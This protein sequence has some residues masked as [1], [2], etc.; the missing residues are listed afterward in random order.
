MSDFYQAVVESIDAEGGFSNNP[1]D[2][3]NWTSGIVGKGELKGTKY[4]ISAAS[5]PD[6]DIENL[7]VDDAK[8]IYKR[9]WWDKYHYGAIESQELANKVFDVSINMGATQAH[10]LLQRATW[11]CNGYLSIK[12]DG[13]IGPATLSAL[14]SELHSIALLC[15]FKSEIAGFYRL[16]AKI[17]TNDKEN[18]SGWLKNRAYS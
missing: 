3:G 15:A 16:L 13:K 14:N 11:T 5:Y 18:L 2:N 1:K 6:L 12:D 10:K 17:S 9:D 8:S 7:T 4:G